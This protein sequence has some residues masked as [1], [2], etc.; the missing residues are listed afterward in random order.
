MY[1]GRLH[2]FCKMAGLTSQ[3]AG[4][5]VLVVGSALGGESIAAH[6]MGAASVVGL[7]VD[8]ALVKRSREIALA[9]GLSSLQFISF[10]GAAFP[11]LEPVDVVL[12]G[13][14]IEHTARPSFHLDE[15]LRALK[16]D[17]YLFLEFPTRFHR[18]ELHT[19]L[20]SFEWL[21]MPMRNG[22]NSLAGWI[23]SIGHRD[24][25]SQRAARHEI[26]HELRQISTIQIRLWLR[27]RSRVAIIKR[28]V[29]APGIV[30]LCIQKVDN[31]AAR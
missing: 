3:F 27:R 12:S 15:C 29:P 21:P 16:P 4:M 19:G 30:R 20:I 17:G 25:A 8:P 13:H 18:R 5:S 10:D 2:A 7:D 23:S 11:G 26:N 31:S 28:D 1:S 14:V 9:M 24:A 22:M 6:G